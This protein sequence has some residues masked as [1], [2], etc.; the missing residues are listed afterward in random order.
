VTSLARLS[1]TVISLALLAYLASVVG[2]EQR[3]AREAALSLSRYDPLTGLYNRA[4]F[5]SVLDREIRRAARNGSRLAVLMLDLDDLKPVND[6]FGHQRGDE[7]LRAVTNAI[8]RNVRSTDVAARYGGDEFVVLLSDTEPEGALVVAEKL[9]TDIS[10]LAVGSAERPARTSASI[11]VVTYPDDGATMEGLIADV[12]KAMYEAKRRGKN[13]IVG[14]VTRTERVTTPFGEERTTIMERT[15]RRSGS[16]PQPQPPTAT[17]RPATPVRAAAAAPP[18]TAP[19]SRPTWDSTT[20]AAGSGAGRV[21][22][23]EPRP[24]VAF[25]I[26]RGPADERPPTQARDTRDFSGR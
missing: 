4:Y 18:P 1:F 12:D 9:R 17:P 23:G 26:D 8:E 21:H 13:Q 7:L 14:Y 16:V 20:P 22:Q 10:N 15:G 2:R 6:T 24:Y 3:R 11:G 25:P 19:P 5:F